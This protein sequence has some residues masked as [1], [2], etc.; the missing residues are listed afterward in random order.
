MGS[1]KNHNGEGVFSAY[2]YET[3]PGT[4][5]TMYG[6][7]LKVIKLVVDKDGKNSNLPQCSASSDGYLCLGKDGLP[8]Q[9][10]IY[11]DHNWSVD[12]DWGHPHTNYTKYGGDGRHFDKGTVHVQEYGGGSDR[13]SYGARYMNNDEMETIGKIIHHFNPSVKLRP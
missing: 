3:V 9:L 2:L 4:E 7:K 8:K 10:R 6:L 12:Y 11:K 5:I 13:N 1:Q